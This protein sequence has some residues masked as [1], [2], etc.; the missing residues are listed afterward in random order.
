MLESNPKSN[1]LAWTRIGEGGNITQMEVGKQISEIQ[2]EKLPQILT[3]I[4]V[5]REKKGTSETL[6]PWIREVR[7]EAEKLGEKTVVLQLHQEEFLSAQH[8]VMEEKSKGFSLNPFRALK[9]M[10]LM[11]V[12]SR[13]MDKYAKENA[14]QIDGIV[15]ARVLR[16]LGRYQDYKGH[17]DKSENY[18]RKGLEFFESRQT[19]Q[20]KFN[21][22]EFAGFLSFSLLKQGKNMEGITLMQ[23]TLTDFDESPEGTWLKSNDYYTWAVWK[24]GIQIRSAEAMAKE[25]GGEY[26]ATAT[27]LILDAQKILVMPGGD[28]EPFRL[29]LDE[30]TVVKKLLKING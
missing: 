14:G 30:L 2:K 8:M 17:Y 1:I 29:R 16:F 4:A 15:G 24:S 22:L 28:T 19:P 6:I 23:Q 9:G 18:Y 26:K 10:Y 25:E 3:D 5:S 27:N 7:K 11:E 21:K 12:T 13:A 20:E